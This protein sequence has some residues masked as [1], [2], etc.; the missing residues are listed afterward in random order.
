MQQEKSI[1]RHPSVIVAAILALLWFSAVAFGVAISAHFPTS[2]DELEHLSFIRSLAAD[3]TF[4]PKYGTYPTLSD[5]LTHWTPRINYLAHPPLYYLLMAALPVNV[6]VL[7]LANLAIALVGT[8]CSI[9][10]LAKLA[11]SPRVAVLATLLIATFFRSMVTAGMINNDNLVVLETGL[12]LLTLASTKDRAVFQA[13]LLA[14]AGWTKLNAFVALTLIVAIVHL[15]EIAH[16]RAPLLGR[17]SFAL[18]LGVA[19]GL[20]PSGAN[21]LT[22]HTVVYTPHDF[23]FVPE[24]ARQHLD[25]PGFVS[26]FIHRLGAKFPLK[27]NSFDA[28]Y[29]LGLALALA[30]IAL[31]LERK[32]AR[33]LAVAFLGALA[34]FFAIHLFYA[35]RSFTSLGSISDAQMR[36]YNALWPGFAFALAVAVDAMIPF[37]QGLWASG[38]RSFGVITEL[39]PECRDNAAV[40]CEGGLR[41]HEIVGANIQRLRG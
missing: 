9:V 29:L 14:V 37:V 21:L 8:A 16:E 22:L 1:A 23:L 27:E 3:P 6:L 12:I 41:W 40:K 5:D 39:R 31:P 32:R 19:I 33:D 24:S 28:T 18:A 2:V 7:R 36:Y 15:F 13:V 38:A 11:P 26:F 4:F 17:K 25:F 10:A 20:A 34:I 35:W 30:I